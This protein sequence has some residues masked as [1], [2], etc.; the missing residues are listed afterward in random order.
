M[1]TE[2]KQLREQ[3]EVDRIQLVTCRDH[4]RRQAMTN[5]DF[6]GAESGVDWKERL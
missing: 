5:L 1:E 2:N 6:A 3:A 4:I